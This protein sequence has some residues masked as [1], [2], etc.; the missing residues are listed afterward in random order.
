MGRRSLVGEFV[1]R[2]LERALCKAGKVKLPLCWRSKDA[3]DDG[4]LRYLI[5]TAA[6]RLWN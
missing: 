3:G 4:A 1:H 2:S 5:R 6:D